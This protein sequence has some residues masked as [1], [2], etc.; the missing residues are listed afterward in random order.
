M[1]RVKTCFWCEHEDKFP[2]EWDATPMYG[3]VWHRIDEVTVVACSGKESYHSYQG[4]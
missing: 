2:I 4:V 1:C 3:G